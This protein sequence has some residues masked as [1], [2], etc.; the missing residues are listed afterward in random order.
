MIYTEQEIATM[1]AKKCEEAFA[2]IYAQI[3]ELRA[4]Y[5][6]TMAKVEPQPTPENGE[7]LETEK[8]RKHFEA[9]ADN[10]RKQGLIK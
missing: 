8:Q 2:P 5:Y 3:E 4:K 7:A 9:M 6:P 1:V 10:L